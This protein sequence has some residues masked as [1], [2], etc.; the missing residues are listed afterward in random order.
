[1]YKILFGVAVILITSCGA[2]KKSGTDSATGTG[3][4][5][6]LSKAE[7]AAGWKLLFDGK[8]KAG[9]HVYNNN[10][11]GSAWK[12]ADGALYLDPAV[13]DGAGDIV[14]DGEYENFHLKL[15]W[16]L[17]AGGNSGLIFLAQEHPKYKYSY[18]TGPEMQII[19]NKSHPDAKNIKHRSGDLYDMISAKPE[20]TRSSSEWNQIE[21]ICNNAK[22]Q[23]KVN[24]ATVVSTTMWDDN[25]NDMISKS[26]FKSLKDFGT[27]RKGRFDLQDHGNKVWFRNIKIK[28]L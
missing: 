27:F 21:I 9:W 6:V 4:E 15:E 14:S 18:Y 20:A 17:E 24:G 13:K 3:T 12:V 7:K 25:W 23:L 10:T 5:N 1:M 19:D 26:K 28:Q 2:S 11:N 16:K 22:L 8:T